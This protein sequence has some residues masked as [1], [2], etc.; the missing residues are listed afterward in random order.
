MRDGRRLIVNIGALLDGP[1]DARERLTGA[2]A[3]R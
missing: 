3:R 1:A 2:G